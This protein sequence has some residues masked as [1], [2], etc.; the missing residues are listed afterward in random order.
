MEIDNSV[1]QKVAHL[2]RLEIDGQQ[3]A[4]LA[5][6]LNNILAWIEQLSQVDTTYVEP[7]VAMSEARSVVVEDVPESPLAH[8]QGLRNAPNKDSNYFRVP[9]VKE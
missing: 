2:A 3:E 1:L 7:L 9:Q 8:D 4:A 6:D 5:K